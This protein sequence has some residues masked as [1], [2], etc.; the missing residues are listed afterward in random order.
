MPTLE[1]DDRFLDL[2]FHRQPEFV[3]GDTG[4]PDEGIFGS[5]EDTPFMLT[6]GQVEDAVMKAAEQGGMMRRLV[7]RIYDQLRTSSC[8][9]N[10]ILQGH[11]LTQAEQFGMDEVVH[12]A[13]MSLY[14]QIT[15]R[16]AGSN[17]GRAMET[18]A[19]VGA[20]PLSNEA[21]KAR[22]EHTMENAVW[23][24]R[25]PKG[26]EKTAAKFR[27]HEYYIVKTVEGFRS[28]LCNGDPCIGGRDG[29]AVCYD[30]LLLDKG[31]FIYVYANS[32][33][34]RWGDKGHGFDSESKGIAASRYIVAIR[35]VRTTP[36]HLK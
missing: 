17:I 2:E 13:A 8:T 16:D 31:K 3:F 20:L 35:S 1:I 11:E 27:A 6:E 9:C 28:A 25:F 15:N 24:E 19:K 7:T 12:M 23:S 21:N 34:L 29:H 10:A 36:E 32:W 33:N 30:D 4:A 22:F 5:Y 14:R 18:L 26:W